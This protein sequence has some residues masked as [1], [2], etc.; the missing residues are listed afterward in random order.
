[1]L[2][3]MLFPVTVM[4]A[5]KFVFPDI[6]NVFKNVDTL[7]KVLFPVTAIEEFNITFPD[8][9]NVFKDVDG[10]LTVQFPDIFNLL[11]NVD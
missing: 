5:F 6:F 3:K 7:L 9:F 1:M 8:I 10:L 11:I 4:E 2:L